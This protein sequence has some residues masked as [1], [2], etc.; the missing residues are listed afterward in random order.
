MAYKVPRKATEASTITPLPARNRRFP[1]SRRS[2]RGAADRSSTTTMAASSSTPAAIV[3]RISGRCQPR[4]GPS[5]TPY[6]SNPK[7]TPDSRNPARSNRPGLSCGVPR[8][9]MTPKASAATPIGRLT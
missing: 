8:R 9:K 7:P 2:T 1:S 5:E 3:A 6:I 4:L